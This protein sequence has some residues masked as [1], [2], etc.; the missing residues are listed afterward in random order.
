ML[1]HYFGDD[2]STS[3]RSDDMKTYF[4]VLKYPFP[5]IFAVRMLCNKLRAENLNPL[6]Q[7]EFKN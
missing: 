1:C 5:L 3:R 6:K 4:L 2:I 7:I